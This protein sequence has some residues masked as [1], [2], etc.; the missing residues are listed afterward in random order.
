MI[1]IIKLSIIVLLHISFLTKVYGEEIQLKDYQI[2]VI[3]GDTIK[4]DKLNL[5]MLYI[6]APESKQK[7]KTVEGKVWDCGKESTEYLKKLIGTGKDVVCKISGKDRYKRNL[8]HCFLGELDI[9]K[10]MVRN[11]YAIAYVKYGSPYVAE[12]KEAMSKLKGIWSGTFI[13]PEL[14]RKLKKAPLKHVTRE[15]KKQLDL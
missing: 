12:Q 1:K 2:K 7:C 11:G 5:R 13:E 15:F 6:D 14:Y 9:H 3:D 10:E 4:A 8:A